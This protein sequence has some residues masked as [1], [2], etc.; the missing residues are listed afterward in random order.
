[1]RKNCKA[2]HLSVVLSAN[3]IQIQM[4]L[5]T[6]QT[7]LA[8]KA[9]QENHEPWCCSRICCQ[10]FWTLKNTAELKLLVL[11]I[12]ILTLRNKHPSSV[13][14][15]VIQYCLTLQEHMS[16]FGE[17]GL[18]CF[19]CSLSWTLWNLLTASPLTD[20]HHQPGCI[21]SDPYKCSNVRQN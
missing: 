18:P 4:K 13:C 14:L 9:L 17:C 10:I 6:L 1:M 21:C 11:D 5:P 12:A 8:F 19:P 15:Y 2:K 7:S 16:S 3:Y 20:R